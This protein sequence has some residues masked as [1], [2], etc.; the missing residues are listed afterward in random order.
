MPR[1]LILVAFIL[2]LVGLWWL[3]L[4]RGESQRSYP[5]P[6]FSQVYVA[7]GVWARVTTNAPP[8][9]EAQVIRGDIEN[10]NVVVR[11][12]RLEIT[13]NQ[14]DGFW[15]P[16]ASNRYQVEI[17]LPNLSA[18][19][20][21]SDASVEV[22]SPVVGAISASA[23]AG[24]KL[25]LPEV[26]GTD[27]ILSASDGGAVTAAG[28]CGRLTASASL[29]GR[30]QAMALECNEVQAKASIDG[31]IEVYALRQAD[32]SAIGGVIEFSGPTSEITTKTLAEGRITRR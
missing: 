1:V 4:P 23:N 32:L 15:G 6:P 22:I 24:S 29:D 26:I 28:V 2:G 31:G 25:L 19:E 5:L 12:Q 21:D 10:L 9:V 14:A 30:V 27:V 18:I 17:R 13:V 11:G 8:R 16:W 7:D 3:V 20:A